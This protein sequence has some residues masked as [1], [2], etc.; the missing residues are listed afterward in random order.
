MNYSVCT[1]DDADDISA[2]TGLGMDKNGGYTR[3]SDDL[4]CEFDEGDF[5]EPMSEKTD[6]R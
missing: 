5:E 2:E 1:N 3:E 4:R 6:K